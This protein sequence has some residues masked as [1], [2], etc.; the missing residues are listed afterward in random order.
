M[1]QHFFGDYVVCQSE[2]LGSLKKKEGIY[3][4]KYD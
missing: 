3:T 1:K 2:K 4:A